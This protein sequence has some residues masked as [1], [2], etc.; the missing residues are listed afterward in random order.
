MNITLY[1]ASSDRI[2]PVYMQETEALGRLLARNGHTLVYGGGS[3]GLMGAAARGFAAE[4]GRIV[5]I[6]PR[7]MAAYA[8]I[9]DDCT[10]TVWTDTMSER[11]QLM[12]E[13]ADGFLVVPGG[14][15]TY[16]EFFQTLTLKSLGGHGKP[17]VLFNP[18]GF[19]DGL[20]AVI[21]RDIAG[22]FIAEGTERIFR[23]AATPEEAL[24]CLEEGD[25]SPENL[26]RSSGKK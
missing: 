23:V 26:Y 18:A 5:G 11:K 12:E 8:D 1:G 19:W 24:H 3:A 14:I 20:L 25:A 9:Y 15:G 13:R 6:I 16:D 22:G 21:R 2:D 10:E 4:N 7:F 17:I